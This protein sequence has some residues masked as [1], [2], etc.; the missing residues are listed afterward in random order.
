MI[1]HTGAQAEPLYRRV[2]EGDAASYEPVSEQAAPKAE[3]LTYE[4]FDKVYRDVWSSF[5]HSTR[6]WRFAEAIY[7]LATPSTDRGLDG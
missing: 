1:P 4:Q 7:A 2:V 3:P 5:P 6:L